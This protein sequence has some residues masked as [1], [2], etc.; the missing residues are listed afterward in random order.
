MAAVRITTSWDDGHPLD[1][2]VAELLAEH[3]LRGTFYVPRHAPAGTM[4]E[5][6]IRELSQQFEIGAH[7]L[8]HVWLTRLSP[9]EAVRQMADSR[10]WLQDVTGA[11]CKMFCP[12]AGKYTPEHLGA[13]REAGY[14]GIRTVELLSTDPPQE[15]G[16]LLVMATS[17]QAFPHRPFTYFK[18]AGKRGAWRHLWNY[19]RDGCLTDW[20][21]LAERL[22]SRAAARG[23][24]FH[25]WG[26]SWEIDGASQWDLLSRVLRR[27][28]QLAAGFTVASNGE[29]CG[30]PCDATAHP[31]REQSTT[32]STVPARQ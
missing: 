12:P 25:L 23:G 14:V 21:P 10:S 4:S 24:V 28:G 31:R 15:T 3:H 16:G 13:V 6:Q 22:F 32:R 20:E 8:D 17:L 2:R 9:A 29:I 7:T 30:E 1:L 5:P 19:I 27:L 18:N 11:S 26:H